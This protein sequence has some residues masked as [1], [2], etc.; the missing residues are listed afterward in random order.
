ME[1]K[2]KVTK[3]MIVHIIYEILMAI[4]YVIL[5]RIIGDM[6]RNYA[7]HNNTELIC[8]PD[9]IGEWECGYF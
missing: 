7:M 1:W 5:L 8:Y 3:R 6:R 2:L 9:L 4:L